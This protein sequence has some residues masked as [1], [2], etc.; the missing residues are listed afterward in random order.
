MDLQSLTFDWQYVN[1]SLP[2]RL[3]DAPTFWVGYPHTPLPGPVK[4]YYL[5]QFAFYL[6][7]ILILHAEARRKDHFQMLAHH[8]I[9]IILMALSY[10]MNLTRVGC[11]TIV[12]MDSC[13]LFL[14]VSASRGIRWCRGTQTWLAGKNDSLYKNQPIRLRCHFWCLPGFLVYYTTRFVYIRYQGGLWSPKVPRRLQ[15]NC[16]HVVQYFIMVVTGNVER[17]SDILLVHKTSFRSFN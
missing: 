15:P 11:L 6:H 4:F 14:P 5:T 13:D 3:F 9:T 8:V 17:F 7:Q 2:T 1:W 10:R 12:L 16:P